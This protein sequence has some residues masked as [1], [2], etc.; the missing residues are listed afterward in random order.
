IELRVLAHMAEDEVLIDAFRNGRDIHATTASLVSGIPY[1]QIMERKDIEGSAEGLARDR[2][3]TVNFGI[4]YGMTENALS[5]NLQITKQE[6]KKLIDD[7]FAGYPGIKRYMDG[8]HRRVR[9]QGFVT[10]MYGR[11]RRLHR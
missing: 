9:K 10:D 11:K 6:A 3:K 7:Y 2:A 5:D 4:V 8:Q 1:E